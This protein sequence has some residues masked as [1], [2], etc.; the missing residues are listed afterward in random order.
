MK[1]RCLFIIILVFTTFFTT[2]VGAVPG[3]SFT[4]TSTGL[5]TVLTPSLSS[6]VTHYKWSI[7][8]KGDAYDSETGWIARADSGEHISMLDN[9]GYFITITGKDSSGA[10]RSFTNEVRVSVKADYVKPEEE[11]VEEDIG[12]LII[13]SL[14]E[15]LKSF[16]KARSSFELLLIVLVS[17]LILA[18]VTKRKKVEKYIKLERYGEGNN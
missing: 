18:Y 7:I 11:V 14:P 10:T 8:G 9:G 13:N 4:A 15:P 3:V 16:F 2:H 5:K 17:I 1:L 6:D 12:S